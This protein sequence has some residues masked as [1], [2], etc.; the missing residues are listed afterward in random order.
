M[1][2]QQAMFS[3]MMQ[4]RQMQQL[5][6]RQRRQAGQNGETQS[7]NSAAAV[8]TPQQPMTLQQY[9]LAVA[10]QRRQQIRARREAYLRRQAERG[11]TTASTNNSQ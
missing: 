7:T 11:Q 8:T 4:R 9:R 10:E 5:Q 3:V 2:Q 6:L 1:Q